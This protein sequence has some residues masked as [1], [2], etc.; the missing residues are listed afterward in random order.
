MVVHKERT[1]AFISYYPWKK[2]TL[3]FTGI[4]GTN[5]TRVENLVE[6]YRYGRQF[7]I[8]KEQILQVEGN[9]NVDNA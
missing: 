7:K 6:W 9:F 2:K 1:L 8:W 5:T 4:Y 3:Q